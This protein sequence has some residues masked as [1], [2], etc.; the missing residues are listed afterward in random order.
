MFYFTAT[1]APQ[2]NSRRCHKKRGRR[3]IRVTKGYAFINA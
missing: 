1:P 2:L 3:M